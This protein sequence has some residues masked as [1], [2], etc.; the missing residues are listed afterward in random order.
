MSSNV[1]V[2]LSIDHIQFPISN[3]DWFAWNY[4]TLKKNA[5]NKK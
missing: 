4:K 2:S 3:Y 5:A 1:T